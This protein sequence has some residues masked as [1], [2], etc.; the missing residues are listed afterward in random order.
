MRK[1]HKEMTVAAVESQ[2]QER[3]NGDGVGGSVTQTGDGSAR[4][5][6]TKS[7]MAA[8]AVTQPQQIHYTAKE[9][10][11]ILSIAEALR[12]VEKAG[13]RIG[14]L[15]DQLVDE[16]GGIEYGGETIERIAAHPDINCS[17]Q[18]LRR[19]WNLYRFNSGYSGMISPEHK[20][21]CRSAKY[22]IARLLDLEADVKEMLVIVEECIHQTVERRL[23][24][25]EVRDMVSRRLD[26][27]GKSR[28]KRKIKKPK[29]AA[30]AMVVATDEY[31]L[32]NIADSISY[33]SDPEK[34]DVHRISLGETRKGLT[35]LISEVVYILRRL[36]ASG[37]DQNLGQV[38][39][40]RGDE[41]KEIG[42]S[43]LEPETKPEEAK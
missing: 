33:M 1:T 14:K 23:T 38:L 6:V 13:D 19:C 25:D 37:P 29:P 26:E 22:Q 17:A 21:V 40:K 35:R 32:I 43:L 10:K 39:M 3:P 12:T 30:E 27:F 31:D 36:S 9:K 5:I 42:K 7:G 8:V 11:I 34:F 4:E 24:V 41:L 28:K 18:H 16:K 2:V 20:K 15:V